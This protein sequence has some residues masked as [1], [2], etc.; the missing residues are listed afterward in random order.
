MAMMRATRGLLPFA[1]SRRKPVRSE[2]PNLSK[3]WLFLQEHFGWRVAGSA[4]RDATKLLVMQSAIAK[5]WSALDLLDDVSLDAAIASAPCHPSRLIDPNMGAKDIALV[6]EVMRRETG[7]RL[8]F[9]Q[10][11]CALRLL[12][13][14]CVELRTGEGK[15]LAAGCAALTAARTGVSV[16]VITVNDYLV[17]RDHDLIAPMARRLQLRS[18]VLL[19][20]D[21]DPIKQTAYDSD[22]LYGTNKT[23]VFDALRDLRE[24]RQGK[25]PST[26][27]QMGQAFA[28]VDEADSVM[29]DDATVPMILSEPTDRPPDADLSLFHHLL[30]FAGRMRPAT[31]RIRD[32]HGS[33]RLTAR[34]LERLAIEA[35]DWLH[36]SARDDGLITLAETAMAATYDFRNGVSY[37]VRDE[38]VVMIDQATGRL[39]DDRKWA[40]GMQQMIE[41]KEGMEPSPEFRTVGQITQQTYFRQYRHLSGLTGTARECRGEFW[42]IY[43]LSVSAVAPHAPPQLR[44]LGFHLHRNAAAKWDAVSDEAIGISE[45]RSVLIGINDV[46][47]SAELQDTFAAK[48]HDVAVLD[49]LTEAQ[50]ADLIAV[51][52]TPGRITI[53]T[54][55]AGRGTDIGL[56]PEVREAGGL[57]VII[58]SIMASGRLERQL[59]G[60]AGR[61]GD[62]GSY[63]RHI[64]L[65]D[66]GLNEGAM[67]PARVLARVLIKL[68]ILPRWALAQNQA[69]R[70]V[71]ARSQRRKTLI[72][73][74]E[75]ARQLGYG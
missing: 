23:F 40:Y 25:D 53:A 43:G 5:A 63:S 11:E 47:E 61:Q 6:L 31:E 2:V 30:D 62:P 71:K 26:S 36:P 15:T 72:R 35:R 45:A 41:L 67:S 57:H 38:V 10:I 64:S 56:E 7:F 16:H 74:Q 75:L 12:G 33:W 27:R 44:D 21:K 4:R 37:I 14:Q 19:Q 48:G 66:R 20:K 18:A 65:T 49:A 54:H 32:T 52:G 34:G 39:M 51:A 24:K 42:A 3:P 70:D 60:R 50:E 13:G 59:Y 8:R 29:V 9:N 17:Q 73:E 22:I 1:R 28:I 46:A 58:G 68:R 55:L 69:A